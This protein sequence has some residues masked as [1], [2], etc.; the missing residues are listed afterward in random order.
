MNFFFNLIKKRIGLSRIGRVNFSN[1]TSNYQNTP[2]IAF[3]LNDVIQ[4]NKI[5]T[6]EFADQ[7]L[8][9]L[10]DVKFFDFNK[11]KKTFKKAD[12]IYYHEGF[13]NIFKKN[14]EENLEIYTNKKIFP[15]IPFNTPNVSL[16]K[17]FAKDEI[18]YHLKKI[19]KLLQKY[20]SINFGVAIRTF[21]YP[22]LVELYADL[23]NHN[24][25][26]C[27]IDLRDIFDNIN[28]FRKIINAF[29]KIKEAF[30]N[31]LVLMCSGKILPKY[32]P[33]MVYLGIDIINCS[34]TTYYASENLYDTVEYLLPIYKIQYL[35][36]SCSAC[37]KQLRFLL[38]EKN[39]LQKMELTYLHDLIT[40]RDYWAKIQL[41]LD[42]KDFRAFV[43]KSTL[44]DLNLISMLRI[45]DRE[46]FSFIQNYTPI[47]QKNN[48]IKSFGAISYHRPDFQKF[49]E[50]TIKNFT[51]DSS[52]KLILLF[53]CSAKKPYSS[54]KSH[55][56]FNRILKKFSD[57]SNFQE[58]ILTSPLGAIPRQL[59]EIYP[60]NSYDISVTGEWDHEELLLSSSMLINLIKKYDKKI[61]I[62]SHLDGGYRE[63]VRIIQK[64]LK[65][66]FYF[67]KIEE[68]VTS[69]KSLDSLE[70]LIKEHKD[71][72]SLNKIDKE[73]REKSNQMNNKIEKMIDYQ[74]GIGLGS[75]FS[76][77]GLITKQGRNKNH[78]NIVDGQ[79]KGL[80]GVFKKERGQIFLTLKGA[81]K[82]QPLLKKSNLIIF[83]GDR[84]NGSTIFRPGIVE[85][86]ENLLP[87]SQVIILDKKK[88]NVI[89]VGEMIVG[90]YFINKSNTGRIA[91]I[92]EKLK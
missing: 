33:M 89:G 47:S 18:A 38:K 23:I 60:V 8:F 65:N 14:L 10:S 48:V 46:H 12:F 71:D 5:F 43:E 19:S 56:K 11:I 13:Y 84:I 25:N 80:I 40:A 67:S 50:K 55:Q 16:N 42:S 9:V 85:F 54:S 66:D 68:K 28:K 34:Y 83:D 77:D 58:I 78:L 39:S 64:D 49:R 37:R 62:I 24:D 21:N 51:P 6:E 69:N 20:P 41:Y 1:N 27:L 70:E 45:L 52:T 26:I 57:S 92:Y 7:S 32:Y 22:E 3:P 74:F 31:N 2:L 35:P 44:D 90:S 81:L 29:I 75:L 79:K 59:E 87:N 30:N 73:K 53:P 76:S 72:Y 17:E 91:S 82:L 86:S 15:I 4:N 36:C 61:P 88:K 63:I